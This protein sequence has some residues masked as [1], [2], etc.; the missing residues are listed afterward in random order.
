[1]NKNSENNKNYFDP[2]EYNSLIVGAEEKKASAKNKASLIA[3]LTDSHNRDVRED[4]LKLIKKEPRSLEFLIDAIE[5]KKL[6]K[7]RIELISACWESGIDCRNKLLYFV[8]LATSSDYL[9]CIEAFSVVDGM[10]MPLD[11]KELQK[12]IEHL[13]TYL[14]SSSDEKTTLLK[15]LGLLLESY[16][17]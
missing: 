11:Q 5:D 13:N 3:L 12:S 2:K 8:Q 16:K 9:C 1:M 17:E 10:D 7:Y 14:S 4:V 6:K 15:E